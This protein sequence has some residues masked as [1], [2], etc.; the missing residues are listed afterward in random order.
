MTESRP[1][2]ASTGRLLLDQLV[3][4]RLQGSAAARRA[5]LELV[6]KLR[7]CVT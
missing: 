1:K 6:E 3:D 4:P 2:D 7:R 5:G